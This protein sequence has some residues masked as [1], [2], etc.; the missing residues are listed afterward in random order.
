MM[1][2][3]TRTHSPNPAPTAEPVP[4]PKYSQGDWVSYRAYNSVIEG[5]I[6][7]IQRGGG[8]THYYDI[9]GNGRNST[10]MIHQDR[11]I[12][13][14]EPP[15]PLPTICYAIVMTKCREICVERRPTNFLDRPFFEKINSCVIVQQKFDT[16]KLALDH[17]FAHEEEILTIDRSL[18]LADETLAE[19]IRRKMEVKI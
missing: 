3:F 11:I 1:W 7:T 17:L 13:K 14:I 4:E 9:R 18:H 10:D 12:E 15:A 16:P 19:K 2:P 5:Q 6:Q 8:S